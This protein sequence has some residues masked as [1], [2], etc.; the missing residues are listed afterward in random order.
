MTIINNAIEEAQ[1]N[2]DARQ[3][4]ISSILPS[5]PTLPTAPPDL[6]SAP[7]S[8]DALLNSVDDVPSILPESVDFTEAGQLSNPTIP[9]SAVTEGFE[10]VEALPTSNSNIQIPEVNPYQEGNQLYDGIP[11]QFDLGSPMNLPEVAAPNVAAES[12]PHLENA[13]R[14]GLDSTQNPFRDRSSR[15]GALGTFAYNL[16]DT[17]FGLEE[18]EAV[19]LFG[20]NFGDF[21]NGALGRFFYGLG[22]LP[23]TAMGA[24]A[25]LGRSVGARV[26]T[27]QRG[28]A[29]TLDRIADALT[30]IPIVGAFA[31]GI[32]RS[33]QYVEGVR[34]FYRLTEDGTHMPYVAR[35]LQGRDLSF[36]SWQVNESGAFNPFGVLGDIRETPTDQLPARF[37]LGLVLD[38]VTDPITGPVNDALANARRAVTASTDTT[39]ALVRTRA[40]EFDIPLTPVPPPSGLTV[41]RSTPP[42]LGIPTNSVTNRFDGNNFT[43]L[44]LGEATIEPRVRGTSG[45]PQLP[46][47]RA[48]SA[49][50]LPPPVDVPAAI[51]LSPPSPLARI[52]NIRIPSTET[53]AQSIVPVT[54]NPAVN[55]D[56]F[57][58]QLPYERMPTRFLTGETTIEPS[59]PDVNAQ[60]I[61]ALVGNVVPRGFSFSDT[62]RIV[63]ALR[64][65]NTSAMTLYNPPTRMR[66]VI[67]PVEAD[68]PE[69][70]AIQ[71][72]DDVRFA[73]IDTAAREMQELFESVSRMGDNVDSQVDES[74]P[75]DTQLDEA[76]A[77]GEAQINDLLA[78]MPEDWIEER[79]ILQSDDARFSEL[80]PDIQE[81]IDELDYIVET[82]ATRLARSFVDDGDVSISTVDEFLERLDP[83]VAEELAPRLRQE[84]NTIN[85]QGQR[86]TDALPEGVIDVPASVVPDVPES[87]I[88]V[89]T[90]TTDEV[91]FVN[92]SADE[93]EWDNTRQSRMDGSRGKIFTSADNRSITKVLFNH[94]DADSIQRVISNNLNVQRRLQDTDITPRMTEYGN[95]HITYDYIQSESLTKLISDAVDNP[96]A[97]ERLRSLYPQIGETTRLLDNYRVRHNDFSPN[98][99]LV[100]ADNQIKIIDFDDSFTSPLTDDIVDFNNFDIRGIAV[101]NDFIIRNKS[102]IADIER[103]IRDAAR[104]APVNDEALSAVSKQRF[105]STLEPGMRSYASSQLNR[106]RTVNLETIQRYLNTGE[107]TPELLLTIRNQPR[108]HGNVKVNPTDENFVSFLQN[109]PVGESRTLDE[110]SQVLS[111]TKPLDDIPEDVFERV[112][113][114]D[115]LQFDIASQNARQL[116]DAIAVFL[117]DT[118]IK[119][120]SDVLFTEVD[121]P[122]ARDS[123]SQHLMR[124]VI[125]PDVYD[126]EARLAVFRVMEDRFISNRSQPSNEYLDTLAEYIT[127]RNQLVDSL[128]QN[129]QISSQY[130]AVQGSKNPDVHILSELEEALL[131]SNEVIDDLVEQTDTLEVRLERRAADDNQYAREEWLE[132]ESRRDE[133]LGNGYRG[134]CL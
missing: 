118:Q 40:T 102:T 60:V 57:L 10:Q 49:P 129:S 106:I 104:I 11:T 13:L 47:S 44:D 12:F 125:Q 3:Q 54:P 7:P 1:P 124:N 88:D 84:L 20:N 23:N 119:R 109:I 48:S 94:L 21:G 52:D 113:D 51:Q 112:F 117:P 67:D 14:G 36:S 39:R 8:P 32:P 64:G 38:I 89:P 132:I 26:D 27:T 100:T 24:A 126:S 74:I 122:A 95:R 45:V 43:S 101:D 5:P 62:D 41:L 75:F 53:M 71:I 87:T 63:F 108:I 97:M 98:N 28:N 123:A 15:Y 34:E 18:N 114:S 115:V 111:S 16:V 79:A 99:I 61:N 35:A 96:E 6:G 9:E 92:R 83:V 82:T 37:V 76:L 42:T 50:A 110:L 2:D 78:R 68:L 46:A 69:S 25:D 70:V 80:D 72:A 66:Q 85:V 116:N 81:F 29:T 17:L 127:I 90:R 128:E 121:T 59:T 134:G 86:V 105:L 130:A 4:I 131:R 107:V 65:N 103:D 22:L 73:P 30:P 55:R 93:I 56:Y 33:R 120:L 58:P 91:P 133:T 77:E 19:G 31:A